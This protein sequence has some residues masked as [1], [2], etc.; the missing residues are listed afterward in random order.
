MRRN[1]KSFSFLLEF[2]L[3]LLFFSISSAVCVHIQTQA[4]IM[5]QKA[6]DTKIAIQLIQNYMSDDSLPTSYDE[7][8]N[9]SDNT[10]FKIVEERNNQRVTVS[11][12]VEDETLISLP[13]YVGGNE[14]ER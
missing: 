2:I 13:H 7:K 6:N 1:T 14:Y 4:S 10:Y 11:V 8:G 9:P 12:I 3:V 5:N